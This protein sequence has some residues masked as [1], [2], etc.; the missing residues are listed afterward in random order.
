[1]LQDA[2][3]ILRYYLPFVVIMIIL[4]SLSILTGCAS[5]EYRE[6]MSTVKT[7]PEVMGKAISAL[8]MIKE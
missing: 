8:I 3:K 2:R 4:F 7:F 5:P 6:S 1:M